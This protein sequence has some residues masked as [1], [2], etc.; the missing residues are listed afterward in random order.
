M[1]ARRTRSRLDAAGALIA[2]ALW[3][4]LA[5][6]LSSEGVQRFD[7]AVRLAV[8]RWASP[9]LTA[10]MQ[11]IAVLG[12]VGFLAAA[13]LVAIAGLLVAGRRRSAIA[14]AGTMAGAFLLENAMKYAIH[15]VRP[16]PFFGTEPE[17]YSFP[18]GHALFS[19][20]FYCTLASGLAQRRRSGLARAAIGTAA[21]ALIAAIG[22]SRIYLGVHYPSDVL[23][24]YLAAAFW[25]GVVAAIR[26]LRSRR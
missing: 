1:I 9:N 21:A 13:A 26:G 6:A 4:G 14:L 25:L 18:S 2:L 10:L 17:T 22:L 23:G 8:H 16:E 19:L 12:S 24:G 7:A 15:R 20:C 3:A 11:G 5:A